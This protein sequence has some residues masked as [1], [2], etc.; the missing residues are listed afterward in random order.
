MRALVAAALLLAA[1]AQ[2][3]PLTCAD[4]DQVC[5]LGAPTLP[6][7]GIEVAGVQATPD[8]ARQAGE[9]EPFIINS[10]FGD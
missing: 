7:P 10:G 4:D 9:D 2:E 6:Q 1:Y 3:L 5:E 8:D